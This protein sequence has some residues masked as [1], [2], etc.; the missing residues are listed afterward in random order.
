MNINFYLKMKISIF[1]EEYWHHVIFDTFNLHLICKY[2]FTQLSKNFW[3]RK[4]LM[5]F[6]GMI[7]ILIPPSDPSRLS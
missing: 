4:F 3:I 2:F 1:V 6:Q 7:L 5:G